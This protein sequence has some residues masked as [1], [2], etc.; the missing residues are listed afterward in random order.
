MPKTE[1]KPRPKPKPLHQTPGAEAWEEPQPTSEARTKISGA[2]LL[3]K[4]IKTVT[5]TLYYYWLGVTADCPCA[6]LDAG[7]VRF[8][9]MQEMIEPDPIRKGQD[10]R[11]PVSGSI[12][13]LSEEHILAIVE[14]LPRLMIRLLAGQNGPVKGYGVRIPT[15]EQVQ[16]AR[17]LGRPMPKYV[18]QPGDEFA[19]K[20]MYAVLCP[21]QDNP[22]RGLHCPLSL[23][24][25]GLEW[26][27]EME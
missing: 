14:E 17:R 10:L 27:D 11:R 15:E 9:M 5:S 19:V 12:Q 6:H 4:D 25:I 22:I 3:P 2:D 24:D 21:D 7:G 18:K 1:N 16:E 13:Q 20:Y 26:P 8:P 23:A